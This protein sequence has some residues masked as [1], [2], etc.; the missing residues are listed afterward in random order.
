MFYFIIAECR[1]LIS[2]L[3]LIFYFEVS[4]DIDLTIMRHVTLVQKQF[5]CKQYIIRWE[6][7]RRLPFF[8]FH[9]TL[10]FKQEIVNTRC[11]FN[12]SG[13]QIT[14][15]FL[16]FKRFLQNNKTCLGNFSKFC[17]MASGA[18]AIH[19]TENVSGS[20]YNQPETVN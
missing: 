9:S 19:V 2:C 17:F 14:N 16:I 20:C 10:T 11:V 6:L 13:F 8:Q 12:V 3:S 7:I 18:N 4:R 15:P 1:W 5:N